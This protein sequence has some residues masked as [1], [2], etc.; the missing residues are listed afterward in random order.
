MVVKRFRVESRKPSIF[1][2]QI[3]WEIGAGY[4]RSASVTVQ[5]ISVSGIGF[6]ASI[7]FPPGTRLRIS[8]DGKFRPVIARH[9]VPSGGQYYVGA[10]Y[11]H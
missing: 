6:L 7:P 9:S 11:E 3:T 4:T 2:T 10:Q 1:P 8:M 5:N